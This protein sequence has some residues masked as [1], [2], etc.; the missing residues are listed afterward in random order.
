MR[1]VLSFRRSLL[2][3]AMLMF[4]AVVGAQDLPAGAGR[5]ETAKLCKQ[6][7]ELARSI[8]KHQDRAGWQTTMN[9]MVAFGMK[10]TPHEL[11][12]VLDYLAVNYPADEVP[13][14][15][16]NTATAIELEAGLS[17]RRSQASAL[18]KYREANGDFKS[19]D[20]L[21]KVPALDAAKL[22]EKKNRI[23]F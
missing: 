10:A 20:E 13:R 8:S 15:N 23:A 1:F 17:L 14:V 2:A 11:E 4:A 22:E 9:K 19:L 18:I 3:A 5:E 6:C 16:V 21:K 12:V 7:H